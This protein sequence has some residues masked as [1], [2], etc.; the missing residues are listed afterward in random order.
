MD[1]T[2][3]MSC[4]PAGGSTSSQASRSPLAGSGSSWPSPGSPSPCGERPRGN[5][6]R[7]QHARGIG[8]GDS[9][10]DA[11][12]PL[13]RPDAAG[14]RRGVGHQPG[15]DLGARPADSPSAVAVA[16]RAERHVSALALVPPVVSTLHFDA[17]MAEP[18]TRDLASRWLLPARRWTGDRAGFLRPTETPRSL[19]CARVRRHGAGRAQSRPSPFPTGHQ[20]LA[21][22][23]RR[24]WAS[25][26]GEIAGDAIT[27]ASTPKTSPRRATSST[28]GADF[29]AGGTVGMPTPPLI[30]VLRSARHHRTGKLR[31]DSVMD[32]FDAFYLPYAGFGGQVCPVLA[33]T[34]T[35]TFAADRARGSLIDRALVQRTP[36]ASCFPSCGDPGWCSRVG[37]PA[38]SVWHAFSRSAWRL[39]CG[40]SRSTSSGC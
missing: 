28:A 4:H 12:R 23:R 5:R 24:G 2:P 3:P 15:G 36:A 26:V 34:S 19:A 30:E 9:H 21:R 10:Q 33:S 38:M 8:H 37:R 22:D 31:C 20:G 32:L 7:R 13:C 29:R 25:Q 1:E 14:T 16:A 11:L 6:H 17:L 27:T 18:D 40:C 35:R 39:P